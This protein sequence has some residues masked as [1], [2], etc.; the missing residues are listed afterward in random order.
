M[1]RKKGSGKKLECLECMHCKTRVFKGESDLLAWCG[2]KSIKPNFTWLREIADL[3]R[4]RLMW[5]K[6]QTNQ[7]SSHGFSPR[8]ASPKHTAD[9][10]KIL[11]EEK[12]S[13][14]IS[15]QN[16]DPFISGPWDICPFKLI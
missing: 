15:N 6:K 14:F 10:A 7:Y 5:C 13:V 1:G 12:T 4:I 9:I 3:G 11:E 16:I 2:R 8:N